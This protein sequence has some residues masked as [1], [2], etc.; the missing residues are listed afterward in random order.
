[1]GLMLLAEVLVHQRKSFFL[2]LV[3]QVQNFVRVCIIMMIIVI[4]LL[5][6]KKPLSLKLIIKMLTFNP[7]LSKKPI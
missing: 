4:C 3:K 6:E 5:M 1:M 2:I 7:N